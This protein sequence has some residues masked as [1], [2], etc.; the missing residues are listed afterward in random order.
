MAVMLA[1]GWYRVYLV[2]GGGDSSPHTSG[3]EGQRVLG[4]E[5]L[6]PHRETVL[7][8]GVLLKGKVGPG[9]NHE[10]SRGPRSP[11]P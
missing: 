5:R 2:R 6:E 10:V 9:V 4:Q 3:T 11:G 1:L 8:S 7:R